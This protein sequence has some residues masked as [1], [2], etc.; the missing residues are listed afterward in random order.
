MLT[1]LWKWMRILMSGTGVK[2]IWKN[3]KDSLTMTIKLLTYIMK[4]SFQNV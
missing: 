4:T 2:T 1:T 3:A